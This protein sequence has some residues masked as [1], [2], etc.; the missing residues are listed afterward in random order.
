MRAIF[1][2]SP[3]PL[4]NGRDFC[5]VLVSLVVAALALPIVSL[6]L[7][8]AGQLLAA[9]QDSAGAGCS[10]RLSLAAGLVWLMALVALV[11]VQARSARAAPW[12][13]P[14][15][16]RRT[17]GIAPKFRHRGCFG[18]RADSAP[19]TGYLE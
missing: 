19:R 6:I 10:R 8:A 7:S 14:R 5:G 17:A 9:M 13:A 4:G 16:A 11:I 12:A 3:W 1:G 2:P 18:R 15:I